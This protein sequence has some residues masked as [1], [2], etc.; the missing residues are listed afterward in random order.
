[1]SICIYKAVIAEINIYTKMP[2]FD[3]PP[4]L[5]TPVSHGSS[6]SSKISNVKCRP[7][8]HPKSIIS[9]PSK[10]KIMDKERKQNIHVSGH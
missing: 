3:R 9:I 7:A 10:G 1:M 4:N 5:K 6:K 8:M 2:Y